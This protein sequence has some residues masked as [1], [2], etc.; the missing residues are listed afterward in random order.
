MVFLIIISEA[1]SENNFQFSITLVGEIV[2]LMLLPDLYELKGTA[3]RTLRAFISY[4]RH[5]T[6]LKSLIDATG[7]NMYHGLLPTMVRAAINTMVEGYNTKATT[8][9]V[10]LPRKYTIP[11]FSFLFHMGY[12]ESGMFLFKIFNVL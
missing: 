10:K 12:Y 2:G 4:D 8:D 3:L 5:M 7:L 11:L 6:K 9:I 1:F